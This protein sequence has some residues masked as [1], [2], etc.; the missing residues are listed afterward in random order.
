MTMLS[1]THSDD[2]K[3]ISVSRPDMVLYR[4]DL[5]QASPSVRS[6]SDATS[7]DAPLKL[8]IPGNHE[9]GLGPSY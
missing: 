4:D 3:Y 1:D 5:T 7:I 2:L 8:A 9:L 6:N